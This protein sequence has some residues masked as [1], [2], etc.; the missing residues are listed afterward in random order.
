MSGANYFAVKELNPY[1][2]DNL[3]PDVSVAAAEHSQI[4]EALKS[5]GVNIVKVDP[6]KDCQ[7][8]VYTANWALV[9]GGKAIMANLPNA[10]QSEAPYARRALEDLGFDIIELPSNLKFSGQGDA[11]PCGRYLFCGSGYRSDEAA[12]ELAANKLNLER[13]QLQTVPL[14][15][16]SDHPVI[17]KVTGWADSYFYDLD[18]A[19]AILRDDL[20]AWCPAAFTAASQAKI[21]A[22]PIEK[23][24]VSFNEAKENYACNLVSTGQTVIMSDGAPNLRAAIEAKGLKT[25]TP[26]INELAKG[27]GYI[28]CTTLTLSN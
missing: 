5:A 1:E 19:L 3:Q 9:H 18:L 12:Q 16:Q 11:L 27:G 24:E 8:G 25:I 13:I 10:R 23:I 15:D 22:L 21:R 2:N 14:L 7:D 20:I 17:N 26:K 28:R 6:P 4:T